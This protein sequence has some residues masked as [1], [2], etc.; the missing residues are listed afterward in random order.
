MFIYLSKEYRDALPERSDV[1]YRNRDRYF[2]NDMLY[3][4]IC[5]IM[6]A[7]FDERN[8]RK[9]V[10][11]RGVSLGHCL[12]AQPGGRIQDPPLRRVKQRVNVS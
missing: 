4:T 9:E 6:N 12:Q 7:G 2:T 1:L 5:G 3:D 11:R 8:T 10:E